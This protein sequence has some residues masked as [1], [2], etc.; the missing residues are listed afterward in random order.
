MKYNRSIGRHL[1]FSFAYIVKICCLL[2]NWLSDHLCIILSHCRNR[3]MSIWKW[4]ENSNVLELFF[5]VVDM[6]NVL[7][8]WLNVISYITYFSKTLLDPNISPKPGKMRGRILALRCFEILPQ[9]RHTKNEVNKWHWIRFYNNFSLLVSGLM[10]RKV[11]L[12]VKIYI[13]TFL[14]AVLSYLM[15]A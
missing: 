7:L 10:L 13:I 3:G 2:G 4:Q 1:Q 5:L 11:K 14:N 8:S 12:N 9:L 15:S 6:H